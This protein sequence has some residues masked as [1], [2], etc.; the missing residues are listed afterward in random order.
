MQ[1]VQYRPGVGT[2]RLVSAT[3]HVQERKW[4][5]DERVTLVARMLSMDVWVSL[6]DIVKK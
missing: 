1:A 4:R 2:R 6:E 3:I 5:Y